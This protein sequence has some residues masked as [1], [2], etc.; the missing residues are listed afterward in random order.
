MRDEVEAQPG[1]GAPDATLSQPV[2]A[3]PANAPGTTAANDRSAAG[4]WFD[5]DMATRT[6]LLRKAGYVDADQAR[7]LRNT[8]WGDLDGSV[9][10]ALAGNRREEPRLTEVAP[11]ADPDKKTLQQRRA[12]GKAKKAEALPAVKQRLFVRRGNQQFEVES[13]AEA[14]AKWQQFRDETGEGV[15]VIGNG[16]E[17]VDQDGKTVARIAYNGRVFDPKDKVMLEADGTP[18]VADRTEDKPKL[19]AERDKHPVVLFG[20]AMRDAGL[21]MNGNDVRDWSADIGERGEVH[22]IL[23]G[24]Q[25]HVYTVYRLLDSKEVETLSTVKLDDAVAAIKR[26]QAEGLAEEADGDGQQDELDAEMRAYE[27]KADKKPKVSANTIVT[28][29]AAAAARAILKKKLGTLNSGMD[30]ELLGAGIT[31]TIYHLEKGA[32]TFV[33][34]SKAMLDDMGELVRPYLKSWY[35]AAKYDPRSASLDGLDDEATVNASAVAAQSPAPSATTAPEPAEPAHVTKWFGTQDKADAYI[36]RKG[37]ADTHKVVQAT[38]YRFEIHSKAAA[39][40]AD[41]AP[42]AAGILKHFETEIAA[43]RMPKDNP[44]LKRMVEAFEGQ[45]ADA[46]R[47]KQAQEQLEA[48]IVTPCWRCTSRSPT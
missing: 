22:A 14:S 3:A 26:M 33:A 44:A 46:A 2:D 13:L 32:R 42:D 12:E 41:D 31:L 35:M 19:Q 36:A 47:M 34:Y 18:G 1:D 11:A 25:D 16:A 6:D 4:Q 7:V 45:P 21:D 48:A 15:S 40:P 27:E 29:D 28:E 5:A 20:R 17:V 10:A 30:P 43:G 37:I 8:E 23:S 9:Q 38:P 39:A 24:K